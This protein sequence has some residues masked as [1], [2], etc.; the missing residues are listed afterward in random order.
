M[1]E[2][3]EFLDASWAACL[4][5]STSMLRDGGR[6]VVAAP[7]ETGKVKRPYPM[8]PN[9]ISMLAYGRG[10]IL[11]VP[12]TLVGK[13]RELYSELAFADIARSGDSVMQDW[14]DRLGTPGEAKRP[15]ASAYLP[16]AQIAESLPVRGWSHYYHWYCDPSSWDGAAADPQVFLIDRSDAGLWEQWQE[17]PGPFCQD[18]FTS[19]FEVS[20]AFGYVL[21]GKLVSVAQLQTSHEEFAW[22]FGLDT[23]PDYRGRGFGPAAAR[24]ATSLILDRGR[25][26]WYYYDHYNRASSRVPHKL[27]FF[28]YVHGL[29]SH[30][31]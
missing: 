9:S 18:K 8:K 23:L 2:T 24:A 21:D 11:S 22:E 16:L 14:F 3:T 27:G 1:N 13:A 25:V 30:M 6:H 19:H 28:L 20:D 26:P 29:S 7:P 5:C 15:S 4:G 10:W 17:W 12:E 31:L